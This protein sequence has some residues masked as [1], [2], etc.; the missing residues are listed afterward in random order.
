MGD[1]GLWQQVIIQSQGGDGTGGEVV[2]ALT[3]AGQIGVVHVTA[4]GCCAGLK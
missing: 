2:M 3:I 1:G 4:S